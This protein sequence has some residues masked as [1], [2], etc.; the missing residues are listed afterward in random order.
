MHQDDSPQP[1][2]AHIATVPMSLQYL[3]FNQLKDIAADG[4]QV[5]AVSSAG[6]ETIA[7]A[8]LGIPHIAIPI[9]RK[10]TPFQDLLS[11]WRLYRFMRRHPLHIVHTH[12]PK[13]GLL[14]QLAARLA[15]VPIVINTI[16]GFYFTN[17]THPALRQVFVAM[18]K[19]AASCSDLIWSQNMED[20]ETAIQERICPPD[21]IRYLGNGIDLNRFDWKRISQEM[22]Q[23]KRAELRLPPDAQV[24]GFVGRLV[25]EKGVHELLQAALVV[26]QRFPDVRFLIVGSTDSDKRDAITDQVV[27]HYRLEANCLFTGQREDT[28]ELFALMDVF[29]LPSHR[30]GL[31]R[32]P[33]E[34]SAMGVPCVVTDVRGCR[35]VVAHEQ[36][37]LLVPLQDV[38][39]LAQAIIRLLEDKPLAQRLGQTGRRMAEERFDERLVFAKVKEEYARLLREKGLPGPGAHFSRNG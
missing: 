7:L 12:N 32:A 35:E 14:G 2:V 36:N 18:E 19:V 1:V 34:A 5:M 37:G 15:G 4:Y 3:L 16:H 26:R 20:I 24:V 13:P 22:I 8:D 6:P 28:P 11:L 17:H 23:E 25:T 27:H 21:K 33:M 39:A 31:P 38:A 9:S 29:V 10:I 30:E